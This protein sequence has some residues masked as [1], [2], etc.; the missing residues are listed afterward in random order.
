MVKNH[1][2]FYALKLSGIMIVVYFIQLLIPGFTEL[3]WLDQDSWVHVWKFFT[4]IFLH[5]LGDPTHLLLNIFGLALFG[6]FL[7]HYIGERKF[8]R[9]FLI[10]GI[11]ANLIAVNF[12]E[13]SLGASG[14]IFGVIGALVIIKPWQIIWA[15]G[16]PLPVVFAAFLWALRDIFGAYF[17]LIGNP[18][19]STGSLAH[20]SG[21]LFGIIFGIYYRFEYAKN[22]KKKKRRRKNT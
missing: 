5:D 13:R 15:F 12:Y 1:F 9:V 21:M 14:A 18:I 11:L 16:L 7:E 3:L 6:S 19:D 17:F 20:L 8:L 2:K 4:S 10:T 22:N